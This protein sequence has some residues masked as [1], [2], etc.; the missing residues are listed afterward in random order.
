M[1][2][3]VS[4]TITPNGQGGNFYLGSKFLGQF[5]SPLSPGGS[6]VAQLLPHTAIVLFPAK[7]TVEYPLTV[8]HPTSIDPATEL[9]EHPIH[10]NH[11]PE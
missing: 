1:P 3:L 8:P 5:G 9:S 4:G 11:E 2:V 6:F 7:T 10:C